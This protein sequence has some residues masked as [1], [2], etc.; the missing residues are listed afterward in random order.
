M[1]LKSIWTQE[2]VRIFL[3]TTGMQNRSEVARCIMVRALAIATQAAR[4]ELLNQECGGDAELRAEVERLLM[5]QR[6]GTKKL[7]H[8]TNK[9]SRKQPD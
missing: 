5:Q 7:V 6:E 8:C 3:G 1:K 2:R 4:D 9:Q